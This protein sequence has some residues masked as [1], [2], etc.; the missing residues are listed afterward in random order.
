MT[1]KLARVDWQLGQTLLPEHFIAQEEA[2]L[3]EL[4][5]RLRLTGKPLYGVLQLR[6]DESNLLS[7]CIRVDDFCTLLETGELIKKGANAEF[8]NHGDSLRFPK[9]V[10][11]VAIYIEI[12]T[13]VFKGQ[14]VHESAIKG[15]GDHV[16]D[17][18]SKKGYQLNVISVPASEG[19]GRDHEDT[20]HNTTEIVKIADYIRKADNNWRLS[21]GFAPPCLLL[22]S[23]PYFNKRRHT[24]Q[25][26]LDDFQLELNARFLSDIKEKKSNIHIRSLL[27]QLYTCQQLQH[28]MN[29]KGSDITVHPFDLFVE[30]QKLIIDISLYRNTLPDKFTV[31]YQHK[32]IAALFDDLLAWLKH[33]IYLEAFS[34]HCDALKEKDGIYSTEIKHLEELM[35]FYLVVHSENKA[36]LMAFSPPVKAS[37]RERVVELHTFS[38]E[39]VEFSEVTN[40]AIKTR[41]D[42][43]L[44]TDQPIRY[45]QLNK[46]DEWEHVIDDRSFGFYGQNNHR[47]FRFYLVSEARQYEINA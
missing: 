34:Y 37:S 30:L 16:C 23:V 43:R 29:D 6:F 26:Y 27:S 4:T 1:G 46:Q 40:D 32:N 28:Y 39:G 33:V 18:I 24:L 9:E 25:V 3:T 5:L 10:D 14:D 22:D 47:S 35:N 38:L 8:I 7:D 17:H 2:L 21:E 45:F 13:S 20:A 41:L 42:K 31:H 12:K 44:N 15:E 19:V 11:S 36:E